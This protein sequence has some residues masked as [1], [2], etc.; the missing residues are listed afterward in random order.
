MH[1]IFLMHRQHNNVLAAMAVWSY[2][3]FNRLIFVPLF[4]HQLYSSNIYKFYF[5]G[6]L[7]PFVTENAVFLI[8]MDIREN[9]HLPIMSRINAI[10]AVVSFDLVCVATWNLE[11]V[12]LVPSE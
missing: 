10:R 11:R 6:M 8:P 3:Y 12:R 1:V 7:A 4:N 2:R 5:Q 9:V